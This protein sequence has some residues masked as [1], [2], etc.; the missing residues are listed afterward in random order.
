MRVNSKAVFHV[1]SRKWVNA[2]SNVTS[3][4][5]ERTKRQQ[6]H[7]ATALSL[8]TYIE[9]TPK[10]L[11]KGLLSYS[12]TSIDASIFVCCCSNT[13]PRCTM[14]QQRPAASSYLDTQRTDL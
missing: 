9:V 12:T 11:N 5:Y 4:V 6:V 14:P 3:G 7:W 2:H 10:L 1:G 8:I 13:R